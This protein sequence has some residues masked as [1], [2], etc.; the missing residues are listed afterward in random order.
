IRLPA[1]RS[2]MPGT[3]RGVCVGSERATVIQSLWWERTPQPRPSAAQA[4]SIWARV[5][6]KARSAGR[7]ERIFAKCNARIGEVQAGRLRTGRNARSARS[8]MTSREV[9]TPAGLERRQRRERA[10]P[11]EIVTRVRRQRAVLSV[12]GDDLQWLS[13]F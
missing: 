11:L 2:G 4:T 8:A 12:P 5:R 13:T 3:S 7:A 6:G 1:S 10:Q 9:R